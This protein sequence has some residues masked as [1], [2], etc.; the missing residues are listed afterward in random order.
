ML[1]DE[2][3]E[4]IAVSDYDHVYRTTLGNNSDAYVAGC[5]TLENVAIPKV[6]ARLDGTRMF[7]R[8]YPSPKKWK[9]LLVE[10]SRHIER[11]AWWVGDGAI[12]S[13][14][15]TLSRFDDESGSWRCTTALSDGFRRTPQR[16]PGLVSAHGWDCPE[17]RTSLF[18]AFDPPRDPER[19]AALVERVVGC[20][21]GEYHADVVGRPDSRED[22]EASTEMYHADV[23]GRPG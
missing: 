21:T 4:P 5:R 20:A 13:G 2:R 10:M 6:V 3:R 23:V 7:A 17:L 1:A 15:Q 14:F 22:L 16:R 18:V 9:L 12:R 11:R 8:N 19:A